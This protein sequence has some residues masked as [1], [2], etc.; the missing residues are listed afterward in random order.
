MKA[1]IRIQPNGTEETILE[2]FPE[3]VKNNI[4]FLTGTEKDQNGNPVTGDGWIL[5][6]DY[7][8]KEEKE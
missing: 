3:W 8:P 6:E 5:V 1:L 7:Q 4:Q 2:P